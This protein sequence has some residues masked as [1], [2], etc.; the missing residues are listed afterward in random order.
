MNDVPLFCHCRSVKGQIQRTG[1]PEELEDPVDAQAKHQ[2]HQAQIDTKEKDRTNDDNGG[3]VN[4]L[5]SRPGDL[6]HLRA[7]FDKKLL[8][9]SDPEFLQKRGSFNQSFGCHRCN[10]FDEDWQARRDSNPQHPVLETGALPI[11]ATGLKI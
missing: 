8:Y 2:V 3:A 6:L 9:L 1:L 11:R 10:P 4:F 7:D 5:P